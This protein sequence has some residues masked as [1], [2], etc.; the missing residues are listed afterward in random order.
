[1]DFITH[2]WKTCFYD[3]LVQTSYAQALT[4]ISTLHQTGLNDNVALQHHNILVNHI[5]ALYCMF[6]SPMLKSIAEMVVAQDNMCHLTWRLL[7]PSI[8]SK[9]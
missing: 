1:M 4:N 6:Q 3:L 7:A 9:V 5:P 2:F 8:N